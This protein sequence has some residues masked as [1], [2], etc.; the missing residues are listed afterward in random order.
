MAA[1]PKIGPN[2][3]NAGKGRPPG[4]QNKSTVSVKAAFE[5]AFDEMG[6]AAALVQWGREQP[7][8]FYKLYAK[9]LPVQ[10]NADMKHQGSIS[11]VVDTGVP[12]A[13][14][15]PATVDTADDE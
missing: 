4:S 10:V 8:E 14:D 13:P 11:I 6:G 15:D 12:R 1:E 3:G 7:T 9:L 2:R 5:Q